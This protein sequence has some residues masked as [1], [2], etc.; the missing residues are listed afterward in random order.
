[1]KQIAEGT[2]K[3][4]AAV[5]EELAQRVSKVC[6]E[7]AR[8]GSLSGY[9]REAYG[10][11]VA[12]LV[13]EGTDVDLFIQGSTPAGLMAAKERLAFC[14]RC[15]AEGGL[16]DDEQI[17]DFRPGHLPVWRDRLDAEPCVKWPGHLLRRRLRRAGVPERMLSARF[18]TYH[19]R[20]K[21]QKAALTACGRYVDEFDGSSGLMLCGAGLGIGKTHLAVATLAALLDRGAIR[22]SLFA[23]SS[24]LLASARTTAILD[25]EEGSAARERLRLAA[26]VDLLVLDDLGAHKTSEWVHE[27]MH[28]L[29]DARWA[30]RKAT[31]LTSN[32]ATLGALRDCIGPRAMSRL[33]GMTRAVL[34]DGADGRRR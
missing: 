28:A 34:V 2:E 12:A 14:A 32:H 33:V 6:H 4:L 25:R 11:A 1:M 5:R 26:S 16:C 18:V 23:L 9:L 19:P 30:D 22:T 10:E 24:Q 3:L 29:M 8:A 31:I 13:P 17:R 21:L 7:I 20:T 15:P 27:Q